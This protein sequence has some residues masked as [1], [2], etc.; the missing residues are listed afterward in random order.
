VKIVKR[1]LVAVVLLVVLLVGWVHLAPE[2][3]VRA[4][5]GL[6]R[7]RSGLVRKEVGLP[8]GLRFVYLEGGPNDGRGEPLMLLHGF[9]GDKDNFTRA[10][11]SLTPRYRVIIPDLTGFG[12]SSRPAGVDYA[13]PA[14]V[15]RLRELAKALGIGKLHLGGSSMG[16][17]LA[18]TWAVLH[19]GEV[20]SLWLLDPAGVWSVPSKE[21]DAYRKKIGREPLIVRSGKGLGETL[22][23]AMSDAPFVP[24]PMLDVIARP[25]V[26]NAKLEEGILR[27]VR[28]DPME[29]RVRGLA[30]PALIV[31]GDHDRV[32][33]P[34]SA[35]V[36][37]QLL[38]A[39]RVV[40][41]PGLGHLP[42]FEQPK[43][44]AEIYLAFRRELAA[45]KPPAGFGAEPPF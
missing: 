29:E 16:G 27:Q 22:A 41:M 35:E 36:L 33:D 12:E 11:R 2:S 15:E 37:H 32:L 9:G 5:Y 7:W 31:W 30:T 43:R 14:Q 6:E 23:F 3:A 24:R 42:M 10:A 18:M 25:R 26:A 13:P 21:L 1:L 38:P 8:D 44:S 45:R 19:P 28:A 20:G 17:D 39:S 4:V 34:R 40:I